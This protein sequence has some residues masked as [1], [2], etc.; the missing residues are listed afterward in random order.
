MTVL[1]GSNWFLFGGASRNSNWVYYNDLWEINLSQ[2]VPNWNNVIADGT[3]GAPSKRYKSAGVLFDVNWYLFGGYDGSRRNDLYRLDLR[4]DPP[5]WHLVHAHGTFGAPAARNGHS[6]AL[7]GSSMYIFGGHDGVGCRD[8]VW[9]IDLSVSGSPAWQVV[10]ENAQANSPPKR[11]WHRVEMYGSFMVM[12]GGHDDTSYLNDLWKIDLSAAT[13]TWAS[14][15]AANTAGSP[16]PRNGFLTFIDGSRLIILGGYGGNFLSD[17]WEIDLAA[18]TLVWRNT[19]KQNAIGSPPAQQ[20]PAGVLIGKRIFRFGGRVGQY[21]YSNALWQL[22]MAGMC[23][24]PPFG[25]IQ[26][27]SDCY[28]YN[29]I[30]VTGALNVTGIPDAQGNLPKI[31]GGGSNR[32]FK[33]ESGG[34]LV[35]K[36]V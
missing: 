30:V 29:E 17:T 31:I 13:P 3:N 35:V 33:V 7:Y 22:D 15:V 23:P 27:T 18:V 4:E 10:I 25:N 20:G 16:P 6:A 12:F 9:K 34:N 21:L 24:I 8:D 28:L 2:Q 36:R 19:I 11:Y 32:L 14:L 5:A 1:N 26:I